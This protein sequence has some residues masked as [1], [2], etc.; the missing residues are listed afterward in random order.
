MRAKKLKLTVVAGGNLSIPPPV[1]L[2]PEPLRIGVRGHE[3]VAAPALEVG[4]KAFLHLI[5]VDR[6]VDIN[7]ME[8]HLW[9]FASC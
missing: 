7:K 4:V 1:M 6:D 8:R 5:E 9:F 3:L 2:A